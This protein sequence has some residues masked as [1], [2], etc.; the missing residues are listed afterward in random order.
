MS[1][2]VATAAASD[3][4]SLTEAKAHCRV[5]F[6]TD[7]AY[8]TALIT[9]ATEA[10]QTR[11]G[12]QLVNATFRASWD[13]VPDAPTIG[14]TTFPLLREPVSSV[15]SV[16]YYDADET[17]QTLS[18]T[19]YWTDLESTPPRV[20]L[21][22]AFP[23]LYGWRPGLIQVT[24]VAGYGSSGSSVPATLKQAVMLLVGHWYENRE[25][26]I[27]NGYARELPDGVKMLCDL[28]KVAWIKG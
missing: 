23:S 27:T 12:R 24:F 10:V 6:S 21:R 4:V 20:I 13:N 2:I 7:D 26:N 5:D 16:K 11:T 22:D 19:E 25:A 8:I 18:S 17:Q 15:T 28:H 1:L 9:A 3:P 14:Y